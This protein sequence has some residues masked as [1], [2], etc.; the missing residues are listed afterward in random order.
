MLED[1]FRVEGDLLRHG[2]PLAKRRQFRIGLNVGVRHAIV[3]L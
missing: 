1:E 3:A 2:K